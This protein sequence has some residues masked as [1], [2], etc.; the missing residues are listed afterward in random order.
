MKK[1]VKKFTKGE[2]PENDMAYWLSLT[3][4]QRLAALEE[5]RLN[6]IKFFLDGHN[7]GFQRVYRV[8]K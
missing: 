5:M 4:L 6:F 1:Q 8:I 7:P 2:E 3:P